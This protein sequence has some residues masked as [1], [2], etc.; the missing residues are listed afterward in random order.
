MYHR[1]QHPLSAQFGQEGTFDRI[2]PITG[3]VVSTAKAF[4]VHEAFETANKAAAAFPGW[5]ATPAMRRSELLCKAA[6]ALLGQKE[7]LISSMM[8]EIGTTRAWCEFNVGI[9]VEILQDASKLAPMVATQELAEGEAGR[10]NLAMRQPAGVCL[11]IAPWNAPIILGVRAIAAPLACGNTVVLKASELCPE[12][13]RRIG[14]IV[15]SAGFPKGVVN[16]VTNAPEASHA[17]ADCL[18]AHPAIRRVNFTGSTRVGR[19][20]AELSA[21]HLKK[22]L[23]ELGG[24]AP[25]LVLDD[26]DIDAAV[27]AAAFGSFA[28]QGQVCMSTE[29]I[30]VMDKVA[31]EFAEKLAARA[32]KLTSG[33]P[34]TSDKPLGVLISAVAA[35][36]VAGLVSDAVA[37]GAELRAGGAP[38]GIFV[39]AIVLDHVT[40]SMRAYSDECF[41]PIATIVRAATLDEA[42]T[43]AN[44]SEYG[45]SAAVFS[46]DID[47]AMAVA[48]RIESGICHINGATVADEAHVPFGGMKSSGYG[49][50]GGS[51]A[52]GEFTEL[53]WISVNTGRQ[54]YSI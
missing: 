39:D 22:C 7:R 38:S 53:R 12:T 30:V 45:L 35:Q 54:T 44:D 11:G 31:D 17:I 15:E 14:E 6:D 51:A 20:I 2:C 46:R 52:L 24:K 34:R 5:S 13:Y 8:M 1:K 32:R 47:R 4:S 29:R 40:P 42:V 18:I 41:G 21:K 25:L 43:L 3:K 49:R 48:K 10:R 26:A 27:D 23:L 28:N 9:A 50:F 19:V 16:V 33:D 37:K 36:R